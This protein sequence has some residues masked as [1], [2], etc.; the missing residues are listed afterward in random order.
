[1]IKLKHFVLKHIHL[2][3]IEN[4]SV[5]QENKLIWIE[6]KILNVLFPDRCDIFLLPSWYTC[7]RR[8]FACSLSACFN[9]CI[10]NT[11]YL[12]LND[13]QS[14]IFLLDWLCL[15]SRLRGKV[16]SIHGRKG[17]VIAAFDNNNNEINGFIDFV[18]LSAFK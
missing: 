2:Q 17:F 18:S 11:L 7:W 6:K 4:V 3:L 5:K 9:H 1:M 8:L 14:K 16:I 13:G 15:K 12:W 10:Y